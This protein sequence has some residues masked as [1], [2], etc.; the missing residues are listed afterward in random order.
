MASKP[1]SAL[2]KSFGEVLIKMIGINLLRMAVEPKIMA[3]R[4]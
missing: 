3:A 2:H 1:K 4:N